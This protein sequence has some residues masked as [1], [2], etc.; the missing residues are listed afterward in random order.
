MYEALDMIITHPIARVAVTV[1]CCCLLGVAA[2]SEELSLDQALEIALK[3]NPGVAAEQLSAD[4]A[5]QAARGARVL[6]SPETTIAA[7]IV[8]SAG[9]DSAVLFSQPL[10]INGSRKLRGDI[11]AHQAVA[12]GS[13]A[14]AARRSLALLVKQSY[15]DIA[16]AQELVR[17]N[18]DNLLY[19]NT[20]SESVQKQY[21]VG[22]VPGSQIIKT[23]VE[24]AK[25]RQE[26]TQAILGLS[27]AKSYLNALMN[28]PND[29]DFTA[30]DRLE[31]TAV[32]LDKEALQTSALA[33]RP[34][35]VSAQSQAA[36][37]TLQI[38]AAKIRRAPDVA[39]QARRE[40]F[41][42]D[43]GGGVALVITLPF[44]DWGSI[45]SDAKQAEIE[46]QRQQKLSE[47]MTVNVTAEV[48][49]SIQRVAALSQIVRE[50]D[51]GILSKSEELAQMAQIGYD[52]GATNYLE[53]LEAQRTLRST[54]AEYYSVLADYSKALALLE[55]ATGSNLSD[56]NHHEATK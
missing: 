36:A 9:S 22:A 31:F 29:T 41:G 11:A 23:E 44:L 4:A 32:V 46:A 43:D 50:Y 34:E 2:T 10:E 13:D 14:A 49:E 51:E 21:D 52:K 25:A 55:W 3:N 12:M 30:A 24:I 1:G 15:W 16:S 40:S 18:Q 7:D 26:L 42:A 20:L 37:A 8:G 54:R 48:Q 39:V 38:R 53:V 19:L 28:R 33:N 56:G 6:V 45:R 47:A 27:L 5:R 17:L 35:M